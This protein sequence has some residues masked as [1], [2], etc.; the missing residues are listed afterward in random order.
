ML[1]INLGAETT[2]P[3]ARR[4]AGD[5]VPFVTVSGYAWEQQPAAFQGAPFLP[6]PLRLPLLL[7]EL[8]RVLAGRQDQS[9]D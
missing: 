6:K 5:G 2:A 3:I 4:L 1:D 8:Q 9:R 7:S